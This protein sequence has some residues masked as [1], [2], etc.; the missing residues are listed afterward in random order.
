MVLG[1]A[2]SV[3][4][5]LYLK[6][7]LKASR[8]TPRAMC[9]NDVKLHCSNVEAG[10]GRISA[11]IN[12]KKEL[13]ST[14]C[15]RALVGASILHGHTSYLQN[16]FRFVIYQLAFTA[17]IGLLFVLYNK[18]VYNHWVQW[19]N[20]QLDMAFFIFNIFVTQIFSLIIIVYA[21]EIYVQYSSV[22]W[23]SKLILVGDFI[24]QY[25]ILKWLVYLLVLDFLGYLTHRALH[26][27]YLW[28]FHAAHHS[29][30]DVD[31]SSNYR[32][33]PFDLLFQSVLIG[34]PICIFGLK[35]IKIPW[36]F[37][38]LILQALLVH[39]KVKLPMGFLKYIFVSPQFHRQ[40]HAVGAETN[41]G[42]NYAAMFVFWDVLF[43]TAKFDTEKK[44]S[45]GIREPIPNSF[46]DHLAYPIRKVSK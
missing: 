15:Q 43:K 4:L 23:M 27:K 25:S 39:S 8:V 42:R 18:V 32:A 9:E 34:L 16:Y 33:H 12:S 5:Y 38:V 14:N 36:L 28:K 19:K 46:A 2:L 41:T 35:D 31:W 10:E 26:S 44:M 20:L 21:L 37:Y 24:N 30:T 22:D 40:H 1:V 17:F 6:P 7:D 13:L 29:S 3:G 11:C 45:F